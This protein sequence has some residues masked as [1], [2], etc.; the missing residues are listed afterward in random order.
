MKESLGE[1]HIE[2]MQEIYSFVKSIGMF[3][4]PISQFEGAYLEAISRFPFDNA[5]YPSSLQFIDTVYHENVNTNGFGLVM[6]SGVSPYERWSPV[7]T[8]RSIL[9]PLSVV[10]L[11]NDP[12]ELPPANFEAAEIM[13]M[14]Y[15]NIGHQLAIESNPMALHMD[16]IVQTNLED[17]WQ[18]VPREP[19]LIDFLDFILNN[20]NENDDSSYD[21]DSSY[22]SDDD[23]YYS[24]DGYDAGNDDN[25]EAGD[26]GGDGE[27]GDGDGDGDDD[28]DGDENDDDEDGGDDGEDEED[29]D[30]PDEDSDD[31]ADSSDKDKENSAKI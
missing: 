12:N 3:G 23:Y 17:Y 22:N 7:Q 13:N 8:V 9:C 26:D 28:R 15:P 25:G 5:Y 31:E 18:N 14:T 20:F 10:S 24:D 1:F 11:L 16:I 29:D 4:P 30:N 6:P 19:E 21:D 2:L 27:D